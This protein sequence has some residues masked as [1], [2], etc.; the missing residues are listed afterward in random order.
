MTSLTGTFASVKDV[1]PLPLVVS[2]KC[3]S[4]VT[5]E[6][7][8]N[9]DDIE[10]SDAEGRNGSKQSY[11][12][13]PVDGV[14]KGNASK[15][16]HTVQYKHT[17]KNFC[18]AKQTGSTSHTQQ[19]SPLCPSDKSQCGS[20]RSNRPTLRMSLLQHIDHILGSDSFQQGE[21]CVAAGVVCKRT[22]ID[23]R[24]LPVQHE[25]IGVIR[26]N[27][28][29]DEFLKLLSQALAMLLSDGDVTVT[30]CKPDACEQLVAAEFVIHASYTS[31]SA[32][33]TLPC[34]QVPELGKPDKKLAETVTDHVT[35]TLGY[36][37][38]LQTHQHSAFVFVL[39]LDSIAQ[40]KFDLADANV[41]WCEAPSS[42]SEG[43][44]SPVCEP[45]L[46]PPMWRHDIAFWEDPEQQ[47]F[48]ETKLH[49]LIREITGDTI[50]NVI[51][52]NVWTDPSTGKTSRCYRE[53]YQSSV[54]AVS[55]DLAHS[56]Q[57]AVRLTVAKEMNVELR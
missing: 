53:I 29:I 23:P 54:K 56:L 52:M 28:S 34:N 47:Y 8:Q 31:A 7:T 5:A 10:T 26:E 30:V 39:S 18:V 44:A 1:G 20:H 25:F 41:L 17:Q 2:E 55:H 3:C 19:V 21:L 37:R 45:S 35:Q 49:Q 16:E 42:A 15:G 6:M 33:V 32:R 12:L 40:V 50:K 27:E 24:C 36:V 22:M 43:N 9:G 48:D 57:N 14:S 38:K 51:L 4:V 11:Y 46:F 13:T